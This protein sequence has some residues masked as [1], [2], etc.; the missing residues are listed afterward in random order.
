M[1]LEVLQFLCCAKK[2]G[3]ADAVAL[4]HDDGLLQGLHPHIL[5][6]VVEAPGPVL[7]PE[8]CLVQAHVGEILDFGL[9][10]EVVAQ[11]Y[12]RPDGQLVLVL[13]L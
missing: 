7:E 11:I 4:L 8:D 12:G 5:L 13:R 10:A 6:L 9:D 1:L 3:H 2:P